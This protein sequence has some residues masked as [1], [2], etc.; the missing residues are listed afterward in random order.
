MRHNF[1]F[2]LR[3]SDEHLTGIIFAVC[4]Q[5]IE[6]SEK[7]DLLAHY[8]ISRYIVLR[9]GFTREKNSVLFSTTVCQTWRN[10]L[11]SGI[12]VHL[13]ADSRI[14]ISIISELVPREYFNQIKILQV[15]RLASSR[16]S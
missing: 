6:L 12:D 16:G 14:S 10:Y 2:L 5:F 8:S 4:S 13:Q 1:S 11:C 3:Y 9:V 15:R 7:R